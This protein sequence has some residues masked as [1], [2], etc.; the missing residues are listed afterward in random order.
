MEDGSQVINTTPRHLSNIIKLSI[1]GFKYI[2]TKS[3]LIAGPDNFFSGFLSGKIPVDILD[4]FYFI[5]RDGKY[6]EPI[7]EYLRT[8]NVV[9]PKN[10]C[11]ESVLRE[12]E[13]YRI[14]FPLS[15]SSQY[16][17]S[18]MNDDWLLQRKE[19]QEYSAISKIADAM[20]ADVLR[21][22]KKCADDGKDITSCIYLRDISDADITEFSQQLARVAKRQHETQDIKAAFMRE[23]NQAYQ[24]WPN[25]LISQQY[26]ECLKND[27][28]DNVIRNFCR[29]NNLSIR[30]KAVRI[31]VNWK[32]TMKKL[33]VGYYFTH[34]PTT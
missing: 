24:E 23:V 7:L 8:G 19:E 22:F 32:G 29:R 2:T 33:I 11:V 10:M 27:I 14:Q 16:F 15:E 4:G 5:D 21:Q 1:G 17:L 18:Y 26:F 30:I 25:T 28:H 13:F 20:L 9:I 31:V 34:D 6:F 12:A 3:T